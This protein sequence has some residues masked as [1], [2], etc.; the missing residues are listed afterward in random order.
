MRVPENLGTRFLSKVNGRASEIFALITT[1][2]SVRSMILAKPE[3]RNKKG[4]TWKFVLTWNQFGPQSKV[5][6]SAHIV[7]FGLQPP[8]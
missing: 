4:V 6:P 2:R 5:W 3:F 8:E 1:V 7:K